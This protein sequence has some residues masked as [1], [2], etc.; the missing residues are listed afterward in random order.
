M[1]FRGI[2]RKP[3]NGIEQKVDIGGVESRWRSA[4]HIYGIHTPA[5]IRMKISLDFGGYVL[6]IQ[7]LRVGTRGSRWERAIKA[8]RTTERYMDVKGNGTIR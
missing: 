2:R 5:G 7:S 3:V 1:Y 6:N 8:P 4:A